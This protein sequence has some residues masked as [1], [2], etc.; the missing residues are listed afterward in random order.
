MSA[1][2]LVLIVFTYLSI[3]YQDFK[4][5]EVYLLTYL[6]LYTLL[7]IIL[8]VKREYINVDYFLINFCILI[9]VSSMLLI[10]Y[11]VRYGLGFRHKIKSSVGW[12]DVLMLPAFIIS[13]PPVN[14]ILI[15][16]LSLLVALIYHLI[17]N[18]RQ[19]NRKTIPL[20]GIQSL[21]LASIIIADYLKLV[22]IHS[23][24]LPLF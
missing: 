4:V 9:S 8:T 17:G 15:F 24:F 12:G 7:V 23:D 16:Y 18:Y 1:V 20:A 2:F 6:V 14:M 5:R 10:Y 19:I 21:V 13:F 22:N 3:C 11:L